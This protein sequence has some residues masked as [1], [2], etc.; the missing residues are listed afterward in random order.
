MFS[1]NLNQLKDK[2]HVYYFKLPY[3]SS[4]SYHIKNKLSKL[5]KNFGKENFNIKLVFKSFKIKNHVSYIHLHIYIPDDLKSFLNLLLVAVVVAKLAKLVVIL[6]L[7]SRNISKRIISLIFLNFF[8]PPKHALTSI[9][10][11]L[12]N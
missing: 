1:S 7:V 9:I 12:L 2:S 4:L 11:L 6:K 5:C 8:P 3:I 10:L